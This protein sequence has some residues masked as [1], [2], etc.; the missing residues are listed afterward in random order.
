MLLT[1]LRAAIVALALAVT[2]GMAASAAAQPPARE[3]FVPVDQLPGQEA[4]PAA[5]LLAGAYAIAWGAILG[6][7]WTL[8]SRLARVEREMADVAR[9]I[10]TRQQR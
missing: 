1:L 10:E 5:P 7:L 8:R 2:P 4:I 9:R 6:Y 3:G